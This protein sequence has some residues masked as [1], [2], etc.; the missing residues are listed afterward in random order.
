MSTLALDTSA[1][2]KSQRFPRIKVQDH[3][4]L[5]FFGRP[6][7]DLDQDIHNPSNII[8]LSCATWNKVTQDKNFQLT[9]PSNTYFANQASYRFFGYSDFLALKRPYDFDFLMVSQSIQFLPEIFLAIIKKSFLIM[10][11]LLVK[12]ARLKDRLNQ[13][14]AS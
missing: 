7:K 14:A 10:P 3:H 9:T 11:T 12:V 4:F 13:H 2:L 8:S 5:L 1:R 6:L